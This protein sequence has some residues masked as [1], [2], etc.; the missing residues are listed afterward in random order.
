MFQVTAEVKGDEAGETGDPGP[1]GQGDRGQQ[2]ARGTQ[3]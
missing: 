1:G 3:H 2:E